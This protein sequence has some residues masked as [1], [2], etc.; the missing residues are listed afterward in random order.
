[1]TWRERVAEARERGAFTEFEKICAQS[2]STCAVGEQRTLH[3]E[4][5]L[6]FNGDVSPRDSN[7]WNLGCDMDGGFAWSVRTDNFRDAERL[8][9]AIEDR[10]LQLKRGEA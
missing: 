8:L 2:W 4:V 6:T 9:D 3:P 7:L 5:V 10:V 1:M